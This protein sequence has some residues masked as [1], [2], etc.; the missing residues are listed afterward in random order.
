[1]QW[2]VGSRTIVW[3]LASVLSGV[4]LAVATASMWPASADAL[5]SFT[6]S[7]EGPSEKGWSQAANWVGETAP[8][9]S[10]KI[11]TL[12]FPQLTSLKCAGVPACYFSE[13]NVTGLSV[14]SF[15][16]DDGDNYVIAGGQLKIGKGGLRAT[17]A[18]GASGIVGDVIENP[19][20]L[21]A[22]SDW[23]IEGLGG[24]AIESFVLLEAA[25]TAEA[26]GTDGLVVELSN[27]GVLVPERGD[28]TGPMTITGVAAR[29]P[30][31]N[32]VVLIHGG[33]RV[34][35]LNATDGQPVMLD[36]AA[37]DGGGKVGNLATSEA[38]VGVGSLVGVN[39]LIGTGNY[40]PV[41]EA[42]SATF[43][44]GSSVG[45]DVVGTGTVAGTNNSELVSHGAVQLREANVSV[46]VAKPSPEASCPVLTPDETFTF[47][48]TTGGLS[49]SFANAVEGG[50]EIPVTFSPECQHAPQ[51]MHIAYHETGTTQTVTGTVEATDVGATTLSHIEINGVPGSESAVG[52]GE[53]VKIRAHWE[54]H[55][56][57][58]PGCL[59]FVPT[60]FAGNP[61]AGCFEENEQAGDSGTKEVDL[62]N[63]PST[64]GTYNVASQFEEVFGCGEQWNRASSTGYQ[65]IARITVLS[66]QEK[67]ERE[68]EERA[69]REARE[70]PAREAREKA[71]REA[72]T[73]AEEVALKKKREEE[74]AAKSKAGTGVLGTTAATVGAAQIK[75]LLERELTPTGKAAKDA[76]L[77]KGGGYT[78][79]FKA[80]EAGKA[81]VDWY[82][83]PPGAKLASKAK[84]KP[85]LVASGTLTF[86]RAGTSKLKVKL[87]A[88]GK[89]LLNSR[90]TLKLTA[91]GT[92]I[93]TGQAPVSATKRF[94]LRP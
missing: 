59:D 65:V 39:E 44:P 94:V 12:T 77:L 60:A 16:I 47:V 34:S 6:W 92:F 42:A 70:R 51:T 19:L 45:F 82:Q 26:T 24:S 72:K 53:D 43:D 15:R 41:L 91:K 50:E 14:E 32:G 30:A 68:A 37:L 38:E 27:K 67:A 13:D 28:E 40:T 71:E 85:L 81:V 69:E 76:A 1:M 55:N 58:C 56:A 88:V 2:S 4:A 78:I 49:G 84:P 83:V 21:T 80:L 17:P 18:P 93:P 73:A 20:E 66:P 86:T 87:T 25:V 33:E 29:A 22:P 36:R 8:K 10:E 35:E 48:S 61:A 79:A 54:D 3:S 62:G 64:P 23:G 46:S 75:A 31:E 90:K 63:V 89:R 57:A 5:N 74:A 9:P 11:A 52:F 7:G